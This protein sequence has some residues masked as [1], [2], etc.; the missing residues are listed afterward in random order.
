MLVYSLPTYLRICFSLKIYYYKLFFSKISEEL[1][2]I[3]NNIIYNFLTANTQFNWVIVF[4]DVLNP[5]KR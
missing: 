3:I 1:S 5:Q 4:D 2:K